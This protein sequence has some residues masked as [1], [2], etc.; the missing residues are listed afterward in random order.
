MKDSLR[1]QLQRLVH[2]LAELDAHLADPQLGQDINRYRTVAREQS[3]AA[4]LVQRFQAY[5]Q[6]EADLGD[7]RDMLAQAQS[8]T[9]AEPEMA[10]MAREE[11]TAAEA[12]LTRLLAELHASDGAARQQMA[13]T[14]SRLFLRQTARNPAADDTP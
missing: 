7:A 12:D 11:I 10:E 5:E 9:Q 14:V 3:D 2:R 6:R 8:D 1:L 4:A 13:Q